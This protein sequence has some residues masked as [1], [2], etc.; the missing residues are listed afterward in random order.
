MPPICEIRFRR[1][2]TCPKVHV[3][4]TRKIERCECECSLFIWDEDSSV[5]VPF[6]SLAMLRAW[7]MKAVGQIDTKRASLLQGAR[8][9][10]REDR[11]DRPFEGEGV[12]IQ[13]YTDAG[14]AWWALVEDSNG[15]RHDCVGIDDLAFF[16]PESPYAEDHK[17][18]E[19]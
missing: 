7:L 19:A 9:A 6:S 5:S 14:G 12:V 17:G 10:I 13:A 18:G 11:D 1:D 4:E 2:E 8:V 16:E 15:V 3:S